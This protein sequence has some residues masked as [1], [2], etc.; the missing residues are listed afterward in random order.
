MGRIVRIFATGKIT[1][2]AMLVQG[3]AQVSLHF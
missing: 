1:G 2:L 3:F